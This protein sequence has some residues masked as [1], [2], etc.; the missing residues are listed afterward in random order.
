MYCS[1]FKVKTTC[2]SESNRTEE[3]GRGNCDPRGLVIQRMSGGSGSV[4]K[5]HTGYG[6]E[7]VV[8]SELAINSCINH[9]VF[10]GSRAVLFYMVAVSHMRLLKFE[11][12]L[13]KIT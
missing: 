4:R 12:G 11:L 5:S 10:S 3:Q 13:I 8:D 1:S 9:R 2:L 6:R 7:R